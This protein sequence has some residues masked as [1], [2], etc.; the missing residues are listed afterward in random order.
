MS[1]PEEKQRHFVI[2][3]RLAIPAEAG[4]DADLIIDIEAMESGNYN[5]TYFRPPPEWLTPLAETQGKKLGEYVPICVLDIPRQK[6]VE[7]HV[8]Q[9]QEVKPKTVMVRSGAQVTMIHP[10]IVKSIIEG[11]L[12]VAKLVLR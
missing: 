4:I 11:K 2:D 3:T 6:M 5:L 10:G 7:E 1:E 8:R 12:E 9:I